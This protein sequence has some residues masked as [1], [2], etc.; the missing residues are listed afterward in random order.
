MTNFISSMTEDNKIVIDD[1]IHITSFHRRIDTNASS[2]SLLGCNGTKSQAT[3]TRRTVAS[4]GIC[5]LF[6]VAYIT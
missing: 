5:F 2:M 6:G 3:E 1:Q 4:G